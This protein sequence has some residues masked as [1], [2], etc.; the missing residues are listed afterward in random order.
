MSDAS[1]R[2]P[3]PQELAMAEKIQRMASK[4][5]DDLKQ[6]MTTLRLNPEYQV[7]ILQAM[8]THAFNVMNEIEGRPNDF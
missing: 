4:P 8:I 3:T 2:K 1:E 7:I 5:I 6:L